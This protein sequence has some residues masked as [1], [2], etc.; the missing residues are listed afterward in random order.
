VNAD[1]RGI[2]AF[3]AASSDDPKKLEVTAAPVSC[4]P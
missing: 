4:P 1:G 3:L 2:V